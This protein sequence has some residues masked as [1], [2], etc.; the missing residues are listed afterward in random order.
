VTARL[1]VICGLPGSG[2]TTLAKTLPGVRMCPDEVLTDLW[3][4]DARARLEAEMW[5]EAQRLLADGQD[6]VIEFG[7]WSR[8]ERDVLREGARRLGA[9]VELRYLEAPLDELVRRIE[10][11]PN[12]PGI[13]RAHLEEW[14][15]VIEIP[16]PEELELFD[17]PPP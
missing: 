9:S 5:E 14:Q 2:K 6:V 13:T 8:A 15:H 12:D 11:R 4:Q 7:S 16:T 1:Y 10:A 17:A 3:D